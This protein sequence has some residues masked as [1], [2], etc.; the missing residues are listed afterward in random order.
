MATVSYLIRDA[1]LGQG[2]FFWFTDPWWS[3]IVDIVILD[4][5]HKWFERGVKEAIYV[6]RENPS[7]NKGSDITYHKLTMQ[8]F[9]KSLKDSRHMTI[10]LHHKSVNQKK[11]NRPEETSRMRCDTVVIKNNKSRWPELYHKFVM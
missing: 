11:I 4:K 7:Q 6:R 9:R 5:E 10:Q 2:I 8:R 1:S 3:W